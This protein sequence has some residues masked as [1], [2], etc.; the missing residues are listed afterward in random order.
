MQDN[1]N[2]C[3]DSQSVIY[4]ATNVSYHSKTKH[5]DIKYHFVGQVI[6]GGRVDL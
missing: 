5:I 6:D 3:C 1:V 4:L 2:V